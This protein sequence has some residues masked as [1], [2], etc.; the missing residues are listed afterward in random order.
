MNAVYLR[1]ALY[2]TSTLLGMIPASWAGYVAYD[3]AANTLTISV[4][5]MVIAI[6]SGIVMSGGIFRR[7][8]VK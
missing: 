2:I 1:I 4:E 3:V 6:V 8:G 7:W 5:A